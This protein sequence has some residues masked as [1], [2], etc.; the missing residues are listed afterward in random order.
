[1]GTIVVF[2]QSFKQLVG[3]GQVIRDRS[4][5]GQD[6]CESRRQLSVY[7]RL[8]VLF[9]LV[10]VLLPRQTHGA[11]WVLET[12]DF[13]EKVGSYT[14]IALDKAGNPHISYYDET[15][16][17]LKYA[18]N[19]SGTFQVETVD[20]TD[21][22]G[23]YTSIVLD[24]NDKAHISYFDLTNRDLKYATNV[25]GDWV[26]ETVDLLGDVGKYSSIAID[27]FEEIHISYYDDSNDDLK[28]AVG[29]PGN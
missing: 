17:E 13:L 2:I 28:Y 4:L 29:I 18:T 12:V 3:E 26:A 6:M 20:G 25:S 9:F 15:N 21:D 7:F 14:S 16:R 8:L 19:A 22:V 11:T 27:S 24:K 5:L 1:V 23:T 10:T